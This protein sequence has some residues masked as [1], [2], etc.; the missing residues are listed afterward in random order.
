MIPSLPAGFV[1]SVEEFSIPRP[2]HSRRNRTIHCTRNRNIRGRCQIRYNHYYDR[3]S[4]LHVSR[5]AIAP[6]SKPIRSAD[7]ACLHKPRDSNCCW[8]KV[9]WQVNLATLDCATSNPSL[10]SSP[11][12]RGAPQSGSSTLIRRVNTRSCVSI[13][14]RS[15]CGRDFQ[16][17]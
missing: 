11:W 3:P 12:M 7:R 5:L 9:R 2:H 6:V 13:C 17:Q 1:E 14:S 15:H 16:R 10:S 8:M 4:G